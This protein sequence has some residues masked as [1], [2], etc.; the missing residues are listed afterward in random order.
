MTA[1]ETQ[2]TPARLRTGVPGLDE[3]LGGGLLPGRTVLLKGAPGTGKTTLGLQMLV[4]GARDMNE[5]G[6]V[7]SFEQGPD[8]LAADAASFGWDIKELARG[9]RLHVLFVQPEEVLDKPGRQENRLL[10]N[11]ADLVD[12]S[13]ARRVLIDSVSH[14]RPLF[15]GETA[16]PLFMK[17]LLQLKAMELTPFLTAELDAGDGPL[18]LDAYLADTVIHLERRSGEVGRPGRRTIE[19]IKTR[20]FQALPGRHPLEIGAGGGRVYPHSYPKGAKDQKDE[21]D[22]KEESAGGKQVQAEGRPKPEAS[23]LQPPASVLSTGVQGLDPLLGGG[24]AAGSRILVAG[25]SGTF[26]SALAAHFLLGPA[27]AGPGDAATTGAPARGLWITFQETARK[28]AASLGGLGFDPVAALAEQRL[29]IMECLPGREPVEKILEATERTIRELA[30][31]RVA[32][33]G[34]NELVA[35]LDSEG[36]TADWFLRRLEMLG[37]TVLATERLARVVG[38]NP[39]SEIAHAELADTIIYL[40]LVEIESR[41]EKVV[42]VLKHRGGPAEGDLRAIECRPGRGLRVSQRFI[43]LSGVLHGAPAGQRKTQIEQFFQPLFFIRDFL[44]LAQDESI[45]EVRRRAVLMN[46]SRETVAVIERLERFF[47]L[48]ALPPADGAGSGSPPAPG[49]GGRQ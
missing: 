25:L 45:D 40:G 32:I 20:G 10:V 44:T 42:S 6:I 27:G 22:L 15:T 26:K 4:A 2:T 49:K 14:L 38:R 21:K 48:Q 19:V 36:E 23:G 13:G 35:G 34:M 7:L 33:D 47:G 28:L 37:V 12:E 9:K 29:T 46:L 18:G 11:I 43:G 39:L 17:F 31:E 5:P 24:Y 30:I 16:R 3:I 41:L 1:T 8:Q